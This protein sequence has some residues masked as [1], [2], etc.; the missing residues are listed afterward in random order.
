MECPSLLVESS[1]TYPAP[2]QSKKPLG[3][4]EVIL[5]SHLKSS[6]SRGSP[7]VS[8]NHFEGQQPFPTGRLRPSEISH[9]YIIIHNG[10]KVTVSSNENTMVGGQHNMP[11]YV[12]GSERQE[13]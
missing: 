10:N 9:I 11:N 2:V 12:K 8:R 5:C 6:Y 13:G 3:P 4:T 7:P 1:E